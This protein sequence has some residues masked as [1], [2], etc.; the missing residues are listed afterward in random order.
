VTVPGLAAFA[1]A[2]AEITCGGE[3]H[4]IRWEAGEL[5]TPR[6]GDQEKER[7]LAVLGGLDCACLDVLSAWE[8]HGADARLLSAVTRGTGDDVRPVPP[9]APGRLR[10]SR[11]VGARQSR[12]AA[13][14]PLARGG[15]FGSAASP[16]SAE[17][18]VA[19]LAGL[20][21]E[22]PVRLVATVTAR[23]L[24]G[25]AT[26]P[27][28]GRP[29]GPALEASLFGR[30]LCAVRTWTGDPDRQIAL[31]VMDP[32]Q[33]DIAAG[34]A[35]GPLRVALPL[36]WVAEVWG[37]DMA[38]VAGRFVLGVTEATADRVTLLTVGSELG[39]ARLLTVEVGPPQ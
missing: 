19:L 12:W 16:A 3:M 15:A 39:P 11:V 20:G 38:V 5:L 17:D 32:A 36:S 25:L 4:A 22:L 35:D 8:R 13:S 34:E 18:E 29:P 2:T 37:R 26:G 10:P 27:L 1:P 7:V 31:T 30:A 9:P 6:H 23:I 33:A 28:A 14:A 21:R 24:E